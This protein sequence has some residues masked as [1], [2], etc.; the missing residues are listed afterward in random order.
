MT[1]INKLSDRGNF[2]YEAI[3][4]VLQ[5]AGNMDMKSLQYKLFECGVYVKKPLLS[6]A[7]KVMLDKGLLTK[8]EKPVITEAP[9]PKI[10]TTL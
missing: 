7:M 5:N 10:I 6:E 9:K 8:P 2:I 1:I 4:L 3:A